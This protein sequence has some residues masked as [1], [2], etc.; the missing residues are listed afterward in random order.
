MAITPRWQ[1]GDVQTQISI[2]TSL[3]LTMPKLFWQMIMN[4]EKIIALRQE[5]G[6]RETEMTIANIWM[7]NCIEWHIFTLNSSCIQKPTVFFL[8]VNL[9][10]LAVVSI[11]QAKWFWQAEPG[12]S[13]GHRQASPPGTA[14]T[15]LSITNWV[16]EREWL[17]L[18]GLV[19]GEKCRL[20]TEKMSPSACE[21]GSSLQSL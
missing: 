18:V 15:L 13:H 14:H 2:N 3:T 4:V 10:I 11:H 19:S 1:F 6:T 5:A 21:W 17:K 9:I 20:Q 16:K 12:A 7:K 8:P